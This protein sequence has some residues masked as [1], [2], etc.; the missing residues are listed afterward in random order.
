MTKKELRGIIKRQKELEDKSLWSD[1]SNDIFEF[2]EVLDCFNNASSIL[3]Y[4]S[5]K[6]EVITNLITEKWADTKKIYL[7]VVT[8]SV[9]NIVRF[10]GIDKMKPEPIFGILEPVSDEVV[11][12]D[13]IDLVIVP[14]V[15]FDRFCQRLGRGKGYYDRLL[16]ESGAVKI[17]VAYD[18]QIV[19]R[20]PTETFDVP[21]DMVVTESE[22]ILR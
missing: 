10:Q 4:W 21:L 20:V 13:E 2:I 11:G 9:L 19:D 6:D 14:G 16:A 5:L 18:F 22:F 7:P 17:G 12:M 15:A 8:G 3:L 1:K